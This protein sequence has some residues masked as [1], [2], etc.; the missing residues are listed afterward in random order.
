M[1]KIYLVVLTAFITG[2]ASAQNT[3]W[4]SSTGTDRVGIGTTSP[5]SPLDVSGDLTLRNT[6][7]V[8]GAGSRL[9]FTSLN[10]NFPGPSIRSFLDVVG[11][12]TYSRLVL[13]SY[14]NGNKDEMVLAN[15]NVGV[16]TFNPTTRLDVN[17]DL[18]IR[19]TSNVSGGGGKLH[20]TSLNADYPGPIIRSLLDQ[21]G[22]HSYSRLVLSSYFDAN[23]DEVTL[24][25]GNVG[26]GIYDPVSRLD[27]NGDLTL[28]NVNNISGGGARL[29]FTSLNGNNPGPSIRSSLDQAGLH[30]Y[31]RLILS[32]YFD[33]YM[34]EI[35][36]ANGQVGIGTMTPD[37]RSTV[38]GQI[39][40]QEV[41]VDLNVAGPDYVFDNGYKMR[42]LSEVESYISANK[43]LPEIPSARHMELNGIMLS[44]MNMKLLQKVEELTLYL[45]ENEKRDKEREFAMK[46][47]QS[48]ID[49]LKHQLAEVRNESRH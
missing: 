8:S 47:Q 9:H 20:F 17:G 21:A 28:R 18:T 29:H 45:I 34:N 37:A 33:G 14:F 36:L 32:S 6:Q 15:G 27:V 10:G 39:H 3:P 4:P 49:I 19:N 1:N 48:E 13:S 43:H 22:A 38:K 41:R 44:E 46:L 24:A 42:T 35:T 26:I 5:I 30:N 16:G 7:N 12:N 23:K 2:S 40:A 11:I 25:N 31:S